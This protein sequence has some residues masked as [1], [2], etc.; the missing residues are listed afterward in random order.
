MSQAKSNHKYTHAP[1]PKHDEAGASLVK[2]P[3][4]TK[5][6]AQESKPLTAEQAK[7]IRLKEE[8]DSRLA[9]RK[10]NEEYNAHKKSFS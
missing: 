5:D 3:R 6:D 7:V 1:K 2:T 4:K 9:I 8:E 10:L